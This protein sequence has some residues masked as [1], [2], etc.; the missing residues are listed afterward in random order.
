MRPP[1]ARA[2][3]WSLQSLWSLWSFSRAAA[4]VLA[5][6]A[7]AAPLAAQ[8]ATAPKLAEVPAPPLAGLEPAV[9]SQLGE[10]A[11]RLAEARRQGGAPAALWGEA[12]EV[13]HAY[14]FA[15][16]AEACYANAAALAPGDF[17]WPYLL[18]VLLEEEGRLAEAATGFER[19]LSGQ[20][21]YYPALLRLAGVY[22][23]LGR[24]EDAAATLEPARR[25]APDDPALLAALGELALARGRHAEAIPL[26]S[27]A[28]E[29]QPAAT[30]LH[31]PLAMA[32]R[33]AGNVDA[34]REHLARAGEAGITARDPVLDSV[35]ARRRGGVAHLLEARKAFAAG[36]A[37][38]AKAAFERALAADPA[39]VTALVG[40]AAAEARLGATAGA[41]A[42]LERAL[43]LDSG[44]VDAR[45]NL[46]TILAASGRPGEAEPHLRAALASRPGDAQARVEL[47]LALGTLGRKAEA[48]AE[49]EQVAE[50]APGRCAAALALADA[51]AADPALAGRAR[52]VRARLRASCS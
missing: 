24:E 41:V 3:L 44:H 7:T 32:H 47:A 6:T 43:A 5:L 34:A 1:S 26:L 13:Y 35:L 15:A 38:G 20:D 25:H 36:D 42:H 31:Y 46:G 50:V 28:L 11:A 39:S 9:A 45:Y 17:R 30:R 2:S 52:E 21:L 14:R 8:S 18:G 51:A 37:S 10:V 27:K 29:R 33:G 23:A 49:L 40:L 48:L 22:R 19:A 16:A 12:G 4:F